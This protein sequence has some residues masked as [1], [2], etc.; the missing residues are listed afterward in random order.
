MRY[1]RWRMYNG[2]LVMSDAL[3]GYRPGRFMCHDGVLEGL[4]RGGACR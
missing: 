1:I 2:L 4:S 3:L